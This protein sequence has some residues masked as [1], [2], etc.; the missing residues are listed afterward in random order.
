MAPN[1]RKPVVTGKTIVVP[2]IGHPVE[3]VK[4]P[5]PMNHWF[6]END[7]D[8]VIVPMDIRPERVTSFFDV[9]RAMENCAGCSVTM[10]HKQAAFVASDEV[11]ERARRAKAVN[12]IRRS[13]SGRLIGDMTDGMAFIAALASHGV[14][15]RGC[16]VLLVGAGG[17]GTAIAF[18]LATEGAASLI[19]LERDQMRQ[20]ALIVEL[21]GLYP[22]MSV[23]DQVPPG[24]A[25]DIAVNASPLGMNANDP[26]PYPIERLKQVRI[27]ADAVTKPV[28]TPW[29]VEAEKHG[30]KVQNGEEMAVAQLPIQLTYLRFMAPAKA[31]GGRKTA[32]APSATREDAR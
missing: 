21:S 1:K 22:D 30:L 26:L 2:L 23:F 12:T 19:I 29:L 25:I 18:E 28:V 10:P 20:R 7:I 32:A 16:N 8:A 17:A 15:A 9:L 13:P 31:N 14:S 6:G 27:V 11:T 24:M 3:Q 5:G 4:S